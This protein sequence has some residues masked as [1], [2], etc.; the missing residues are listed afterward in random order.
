[1]EWD[2]HSEDF[3]ANERKAHEN[4][5]ITTN[6]ERDIFTV[7]SV[8]NLAIQECITPASL[9]HEDES[10]PRVIK[11]VS[12]QNMQ[13]SR[14]KSSVPRGDL[15]RMWKIGL[16][17]AGNTLKATT[18]LVVRHALH[19][20]HRCFRTEAAQLRYPRLG[21]RFGRISSDTMIAKCRSIRGNIMAQIFTN[22]IDFVKLIPMRRKAE[23]GD[24][25]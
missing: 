17:T 22:N 13:L 3:K 15:A 2:S 19:P 21:G 24:K 12:I 1:M 14:C 18:Q 20:L 16:D 9:L 8:N 5:H 10:L 6:V 25:L 4:E 7:K 23:N 11:T